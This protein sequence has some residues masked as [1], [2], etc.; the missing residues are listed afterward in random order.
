MN[1]SAVAKIHICHSTRSN[2][3]GIIFRHARDPTRPISSHSNCE[4]SRYCTLSES[5]A[6][7]SVLA[8][9]FT[10]CFGKWGGWLQNP[11]SLMT[12]LWHMITHKPPEL[13][14]IVR[15]L[16]SSAWRR[17]DRLAHLGELGISAVVGVGGWRPTSSRK[18]KKQ[19]CFFPLGGGVKAGFWG[20]A[21]ILWLVG[22]PHTFSV[23]MVTALSRCRFRAPSQGPA[24]DWMVVRLRDARWRTEAAHT[25]G[26]TWHEGGSPGQQE[27]FC[28]VRRVCTC[29]TATCFMQLVTRWSTRIFFSLAQRISITHFSSWSYFKY[30]VFRLCLY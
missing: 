8:W 1:I 24:L 14:L 7:L 6:R 13:S 4:R 26:R 23:T 21:E 5:L 27:V 16:H 30:P 20:E 9:L 2:E 10:F 22:G 15:G 17:A 18:T 28:C 11:A 25:G 29:A 12:H 19:T 3:L